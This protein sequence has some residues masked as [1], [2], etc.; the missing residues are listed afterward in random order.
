[1]V[2]SKDE[3]KLICVKCIQAAKLTLEFHDKVGTQAKT[4]RPQCFNKESA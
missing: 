3:T 4:I 1:M 2:K